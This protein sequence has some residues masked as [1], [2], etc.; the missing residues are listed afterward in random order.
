VKTQVAWGRFFFVPPVLTD[1]LFVTELPSC[2]RL[3]LRVYETQTANADG[4][5][6]ETYSQSEIY[7]IVP[8]DRTKSIQGL[9]TIIASSL[10]P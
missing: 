3:V 4:D 8:F 10:Y 9:N 2:W 1:H 5:K 7:M 6:Y